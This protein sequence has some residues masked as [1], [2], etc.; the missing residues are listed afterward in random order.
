M[1]AKF[2]EG[3]VEFYATAN[4]VLLNRLCLVFRLN[5]KTYYQKFRTVLGFLAAKYFRSLVR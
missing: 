3:F 5:V 1:I 2:E 4:S